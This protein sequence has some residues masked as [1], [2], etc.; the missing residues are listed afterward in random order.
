[1]HADTTSTPR[2]VLVSSPLCGHVNNTDPSFPQQSYLAA[3]DSV[4]EPYAR[5]CYRDISNLPARCGVYVRANIPLKIER[6]LC[7]FASQMCSPTGSGSMPAVAVD[8]GLVDLNE[9]FGMNLAKKDQVRF[10]KRT[11]CTSLPTDGYTQVV[12][13]SYIPNRVIE[14]DMLPNEQLILAHYGERPV[15]PPEL[16]NISVTVSL[17]EQNLT[18]SLDIK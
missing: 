7:P 5:E 2:E 9:R 18:R 4:A 11:T 3:V 10:R 1:V 8:S 12:N 14:R 16:R 15:L 6:V 17:L 13:A